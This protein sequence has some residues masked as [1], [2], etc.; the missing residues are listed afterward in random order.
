L[1]EVTEKGKSKGRNKKEKLEVKN[2]KKER[3][4]Q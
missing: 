2:T 3:F 4:N 1:K